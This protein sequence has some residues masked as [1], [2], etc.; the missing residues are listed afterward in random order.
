MLENVSIHPNVPQGGFGSMGTCLPWEV[1]RANPPQN[2]LQNIFRTSVILSQGFLIDRCRIIQGEGATPHTNP[3]RQRGLMG[4]LAYASGWY[5]LY[6]CS[7]RLVASRLT[8]TC[9]RPR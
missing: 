8:S 9:S 4:F 3:K 5:G 1:L 6:V 7:P 2:E